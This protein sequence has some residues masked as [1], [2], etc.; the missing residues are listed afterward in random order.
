MHFHSF[1]V[2]GGLLDLGPCLC[3][4]PCLGRD[5]CLCRGPCPCRGL[6]HD[7]YRE[8]YCPSAHLSPSHV[9]HPCLSCRD[10]FRV[11]SP[12]PCLSY[13]CL[14]PFYLDRDLYPCPFPSPLSR[15]PLSPSLSHR[16][17]ERTSS[18][19]SS[20][21][22]PLAPYVPSQFSDRHL[23][24]LSPAVANPFPCPA[25]SFHPPPALQACPCHPGHP[26]PWP[27]AS[28]FCPFCFSC[29][30]CPPRP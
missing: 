5:P 17:S 22:P 2:S 6:C 25:S 3:P 11:P 8:L 29:L 7:P 4:G 26:F 9:C 1:H 19:P 13:L 18:A 30:C 12:C 24:S 21:H 27:S 20:P 15:P 10:P 23:P 16:R 14:C 28:P